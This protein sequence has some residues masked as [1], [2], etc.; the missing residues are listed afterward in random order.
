MRLLQ[1]LWTDDHWHRSQIGKEIPQRSKA[2]SELRKFLTTYTVFSITNSRNNVAS[3]NL[4]HILQLLLPSFEIT[5]I[6]T[7]AP[8]VCALLH[9]WQ[10]TATWITHNTPQNELLNDSADDRGIKKLI[11]WNDLASTWWFQVNHWENIPLL[12]ILASCLIDR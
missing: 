3:L 10:T 4:L 7:N 1:D 8:L 9:G 2:N 12:I 5:R 11:V 6:K